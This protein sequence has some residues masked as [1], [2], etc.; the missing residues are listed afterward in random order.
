M[1]PN[2]DKLL[3]FFLRLQSNVK[4]Y[5]WCTQSY[6]RHVASDK[7]F[8]SLVT[9]VDKF[10]EVY[11]GK[12]G[13]PAIKANK[14]YKITITKMTDP[15]MMLYVQEVIKFIKK[16]GNFFSQGHGDLQNMI[17]E[18]LASLNQTI[19]LFKSS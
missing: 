17:D 2:Q 15:E 12:F 11:F 10:I 5:H 9:Q 18:M 8:D 4:T 7:L 1:A 13:R 6:A 3:R 19:Y 14:T 16:N